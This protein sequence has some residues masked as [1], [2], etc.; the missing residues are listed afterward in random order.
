MFHDSLL[1]SYLSVS[2]LN[3][4][5]A[6]Y[7]FFLLIVCFKTCRVRIGLIRDM[8]EEAY[9][10]WTI[11]W[12]LLAWLQISLIPCYF[13]FG[14]WV[15]PRRTKSGIVVLTVYVDD[16]LLTGSDLAGLLET[17]KYLK[18]HFMTNHRVRLKYFLGLK[19]HIKNTVYFFQ[20][21]YALDLLDS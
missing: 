16:I 21:K 8:S 17:K 15:I 13:D 7:S 4:I 2:L 12:T 1:V 3:I 18:R 5:T 11:E 20:R 14:A 19:L 10:I 6:K 9:T